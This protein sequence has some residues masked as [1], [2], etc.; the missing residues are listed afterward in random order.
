[1]ADLSNYIR[2]VTGQDYD[3]LTQGQKLAIFTEVSE[4]TYKTVV[5]DVIKDISE[6]GWGSFF[7][8]PTKFGYGYRIV[9]TGLGEVED[10][11]SDPTQRF[12]QTRN[13]LQ[14]YETIIT[15][16]AQLRLRITLNKWESA[17][18]FK[19]LPQLEKFLGLMRK[20]LGDSMKLVFQDS[21]IR[22]FGNPNWVIRGA[23][24]SP[25]YTAL[26][27][28]IRGQLINTLNIN[29]STIADKVKF[30]MKFVQNVT[31]L[32]TDAYNIGDNGKQDGSF[33]PMFNNVNLDDLVLIISNEDNVDFSVDVQAPT[34]HKENF[35]WPKLKIA[36]LPVPSGTFW[37]LDKNAFQIS[38]NRNEDYTDFYPNTLDTD[39]FHH[40][41][42]YAGV[43]KN[44]FGVKLNFVTDG[45]G[46][47]AEGLLTS[48]QERYA[49]AQ[50]SEPTSND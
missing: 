18:Y 17:F 6:L 39:F 27:D 9:S 46:T 48:L 32:T 16:I 43:Y 19:N 44:A 7:V 49:N 34:Y 21:M 15:D 8:E 31:S 29:A 20:R 47:D 10:Y 3:N 14:D 30:I 2:K 23:K 50:A 42:F 13:L 45:S 25:N 28:K 33:R 4:I 12:P 11:S 24:N 36:R 1:M 40:Q 5:V 37:L 26:V 41:W 22:I 38:P 35:D